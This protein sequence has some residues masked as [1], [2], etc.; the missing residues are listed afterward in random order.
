MQRSCNKFKL[1]PRTERASFLRRLNRF[2]LE[3]TL[4]GRTERAYLPNPGRLR[5]L[6]LPGSPLY[7]V[8]NR[9]SRTAKLP[10]TAVAVEREGIPILLHTH[11]SN[12]VVERLLEQKL[13]PGLEDA[14]MVRSEAPCGKSRFDFLLRKEGKPFYLEVKSCTLFEGPIAMFPDAVTERGRRHLAELAEHARSGTAGG[15]IFLVHWSRADYFL[16]DYHTDIAF[17][18]TFLD[19]RKDLLIK[20]VGIGWEKD[21]SLER[22]PRELEIPWHIIEDEAEDGGSYILILRLSDDKVIEVGKLGALSFPKGYYLY[23]G[24]A[25]T[26]LKKRIERHLRKR[27]SFFWHIDFLRDHAD[28]CVALP[29][30][31]R[32]RLECAIARSL[33]DIARRPV[34]GFGAS[35]CSCPTHLFAMDENPQHNRKFIELLLYFRMGRL[36]EKLTDIPSR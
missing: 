14:E 33:H 35:D 20:A 21:L 25:A 17:S 29:I 36:Q 32:D 5:E 11:L 15:V 4:G 19:V 27:K 7:L 18:R 1:F 16:P 30:R 6:L 13:I 3:C 2:V 8:E 31:S 23:V 34:P 24:S 10:Y 26:H 28:Q 9:K 22:E 12:R